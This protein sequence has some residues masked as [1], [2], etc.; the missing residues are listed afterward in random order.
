MKIRPARQDD[1]PIILRWRHEAASWLAA[2]GSDQWSDAGLTHHAFEHR[3]SESIKAG[4]TWIAEDGDGTPLGTI[5][6]DS[7]AD[8]GLWTPDE[9]QH[10]YVIHRMVIDR[11]AA[12]RGVGAE[13]INH[14]VRLA[15]RDGRDRLV[16][17]AW[18]SNDR[19]HKYYRSQGFEY[20]RTVPG[21]WTPSAA[22]FEREIRA[23]T[24][25]GNRGV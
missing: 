23:T 1:L 22:L 20:V 15:Q 21:H 4:E 3:V 13:L 10:A 6:I 11:A 18:T 2:I 16:L 12:G 17:D 5:A 9:L 7:D 14:A 24:R 25:T 8:A 19:L